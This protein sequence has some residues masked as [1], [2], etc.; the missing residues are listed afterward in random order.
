MNIFPRGMEVSGQNLVRRRP[1]II[2]ITVFPELN[3]KKL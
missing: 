2:P 3:S 1:E